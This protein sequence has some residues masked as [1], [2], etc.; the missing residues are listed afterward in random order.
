M[1]PE[2]QQQILAAIYSFHEDLLSSWPVV[3]A[4]GCSSCCTQSVTMTAL[5]GRYI[6]RYLQETSNQAVLEKLAPK[7][8]L[9]TSLHQQTTNQFAGACLEGRQTPMAAGG[10]NLTPCPFLEGNAC[11]MYPARPFGCRALASLASC[12]QKGIAEVPELLLTIN[13]MLLQLIEHLDQGGA[14]GNMLQ[15]LLFFTRNNP[16]NKMPAG[17][18]ISKP[19]PGFLVPPEEQGEI[20][21]LLEDLFSIQVG[22][23]SLGEY[24]GYHC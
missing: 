16:G 12:Q 23:S 7:T 3:C 1:N 9:P 4:K 22:K 6:L 2:H 10:W 5:E 17:I 21:L 18:L 13:T 19:C 15:L 8:V 24:F 11:A 20:E 14:W